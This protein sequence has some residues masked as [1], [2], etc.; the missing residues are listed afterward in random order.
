MLIILT[1]CATV[2]IVV[3]LVVYAHVYH[4]RNGVRTLK[5]HGVKG[6]NALTAYS[7]AWTNPLAGLAS[8]AR[9]ISAFIRRNPASSITEP[10][11]VT[12]PPA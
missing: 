1:I 5:D 10:D 3:G 12:D 9:L 2:V 11:P 6:L 8:L 4:Q 7:K